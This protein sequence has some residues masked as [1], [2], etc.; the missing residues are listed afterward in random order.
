M[1]IAL[2]SVPVHNPS[3]ERQLIVDHG[4]LTPDS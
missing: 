4:L 3:D 2:T 1:K